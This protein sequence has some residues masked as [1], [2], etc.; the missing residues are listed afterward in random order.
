MIAKIFVDQDRYPLTTAGGEPYCEAFKQDKYVRFPG[1]FKPE[2]FALLSAE[3]ER[4]RKLLIRRDLMMEGSNGTAR[5]MSTLGGHVV[6]EYSTLV[7]LLYNDPDLL[8]FLGGVAG[9]DV[10]VVPDP[11]ENVVL[12]VLH[13]PGDVHGGHI[14]TYAFAFNVFIEGPP[15]DAGGA[16]EFV[17]SSTDPADLEGPDVRR[18]WHQANDCYFLKTDEAPHRV[19]PLTRDAQRTIINMA[20]ANHATLNLASYSSSSLYGSEIPDAFGV[21]AGGEDGGA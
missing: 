13:R 16:L 3:V 14:D 10:L 18:V 2:T 19:A 8:A 5:K 17:P 6:A 1:F 15:E 9:E 11:I 20:F 7:P 21:L 12:N 4:L